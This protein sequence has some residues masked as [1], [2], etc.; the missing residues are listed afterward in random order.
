MSIKMELKSRGKETL[1]QL[2][3]YGQIKGFQEKNRILTVLLFTENNNIK[4]ILATDLISFNI[5]E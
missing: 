5:L 3:K 1:Q 2:L 4:E